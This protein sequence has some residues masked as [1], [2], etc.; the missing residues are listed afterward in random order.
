MFDFGFMDSDLQIITGATKFGLLTFGLI[1]LQY[2]RPFFHKPD[3]LLLRIVFQKT[4]AYQFLPSRQAIFEILH[5]IK[6]EFVRELRIRRKVIRQ[7]LA[8][9]L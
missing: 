7:I 9:Q 8:R 4:N 6:I 2:R 1:Q 5:E 3:I